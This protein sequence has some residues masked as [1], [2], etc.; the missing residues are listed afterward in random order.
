[1]SDTP[2]SLVFWHSTGAPRIYS[3]Q[4]TNQSISLVDMPKGFFFLLYF[5]DGVL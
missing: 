5:G 2:V 3:Q 4:D 1:M